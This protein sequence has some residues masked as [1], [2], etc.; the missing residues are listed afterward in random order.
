MDFHVLNLGIV[1]LLQYN[2]DQSKN[3]LY[4]GLGIMIKSRRR[5]LNKIEL[6]SLGEEKE[7]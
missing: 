5:R 2:T 6:F 1:T 3:V 7:N 4:I